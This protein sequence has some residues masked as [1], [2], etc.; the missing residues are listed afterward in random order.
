[1]KRMIVFTAVLS[2]SLIMFS[3]GRVKD[4]TPPDTVANPYEGAIG[5]DDTST[6]PFEN[7]A[8][9]PGPWSISA[10]SDNLRFIGTPEV[11]AEKAYMGKSSLKIQVDFNAPDSGGI[12]SQSGTNMQMAGK[13]ITAHV[14]IPANMF[15]ST[16]QYGGTIFIQLL[17]YNWYGS[18]WHN[19]IS[20]TGS[21]AGQW[22]TIT[23][24]VDSDLLYNSKT[25]SQNGDNGNTA[26]LWGVKVGQGGKD[27]QQHSSP[28]YSGYLYIDSITV[29]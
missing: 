26:I 10:V 27:L 1:M 22:N 17:N 11:S 2:A 14:W 15:P 18:T 23:V 12:L 13:K 5:G 4:F 28:N 16:N 19:L 25:L 20:P 8:D 7:T 9:F 3:C 21:V 6:Y 24:N 29:Q